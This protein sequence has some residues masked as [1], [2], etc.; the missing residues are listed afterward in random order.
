MASDQKTN[1]PAVPLRTPMF[2]DGSGDNLT[3][4]WIIFFEQ[5]RLGQTLTE[6]PGG[7]GP[8]LRTLDLKN[9]AIGNNIADAT[10]AHGQISGSPTT[11]L[12][13]A[14]V[15]RKAI[16]SDLTVRLNLT[17]AGVTSVV[18]TFTIPHATAVNT[19]VSFTTFTTKVFPDLA[20]LTWD[21]T[22]SDGST[23]PDG[24]ATFSVWYQ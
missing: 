21:V 2:Q 14:G 20:V 6:K 23:D 1:I 8:Y 9:T 4:T 19:P 5:L 18:G 17:A 3:R 15:L 11:C 16:T 22:A 24:V 13:V 7:G 10:I 12:L